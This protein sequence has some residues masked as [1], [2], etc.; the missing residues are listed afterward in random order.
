L[1]IKAAIDEGLAEFDLLY[2]DEAYKFAWT[3]HSRVLERLELF[4]AR[5]TGRIHQRTAE[6]EHVLRALARRV[7][8]THAP[9]TN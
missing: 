4:P 2:G 5:L 6:A 9:Q 3:A 1:S 8:V 7:F